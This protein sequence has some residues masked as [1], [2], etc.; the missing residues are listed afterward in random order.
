M[1]EYTVAI[2]TDF[3]NAFADLP[4]AKQGRVMEFV[5]KFRSN[6]MSPGINLEKINAAADKNLFHPGQGPKLSEQTEIIPMGDLQIFAGFREEAVLFG[7]GPI[8]QLLITG[9]PAEI[10]RRPA[11]ICNIALEFRILCH[12]FSFIYY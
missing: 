11:H 1:S 7:A 10:G 9:R 6:P 5:S 3:F 12:T 2:S 4:K 8:A